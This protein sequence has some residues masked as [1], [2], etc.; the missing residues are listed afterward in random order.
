MEAAKAVGDAVGLSVVMTKDTVLYGGVDITS[1]EKNDEKINCSSVR[2]D[3]GKKRYI[4][5]AIFCV[6]LCAMVWAYGFVTN[7]QQSP[8]WGINRCCTY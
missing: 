7:R 8:G 6:A 2:E 5:F 4:G 3:N 1:I